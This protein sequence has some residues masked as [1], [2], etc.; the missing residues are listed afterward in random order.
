MS[1]IALLRK[2]SIYQHLTVKYIP[3]LNKVFIYCLNISFV[4]CAWGST[5]SSLQFSAL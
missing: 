3:L 4:F 2:S 5:T 1:K